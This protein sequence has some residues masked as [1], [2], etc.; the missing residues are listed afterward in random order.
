MWALDKV[1]RKFINRSQAD[2]NMEKNQ[3]E[4]SEENSNNPSSNSTGRDPTKEKYNKGYIG[5]VYKQGLG[6]SI[7]KICRKYGIKTHFNGNRII[8]NI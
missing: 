6:E 8:K 1:G 4:I 2:S 3:G 7:K 5:I